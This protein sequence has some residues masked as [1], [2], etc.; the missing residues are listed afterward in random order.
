MVFVRVKRVRGNKYGYAVANNWTFKGPRQRVVGYLGK[1]YEPKNREKVREFE[2]FINTKLKNYLE[3]STYERII[4]DL[5]EFQLKNSELHQEITF[6]K[7]NLTIKKGKKKVVIASN[8]GYLCDYTIKKLMDYDG[9]DTTGFKL[10]DLVT[11]A[12]IKLSEE[13]FIALFQKKQKKEEPEFSP[14]EFY[15]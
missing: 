5:V 9:E 1:V 13:I 2:E 14:E 6:D 10:A 3:T 11:A 8:E 12:G 15:Y 4:K 7:E